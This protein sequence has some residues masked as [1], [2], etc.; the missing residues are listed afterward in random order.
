MADQFGLLLAAS[1]EEPAYTGQEQR[2]SEK[3][4]RNALAVN[5][6]EPNPRTLQPRCASLM[7]PFFHFANRR[8]NLIPPIFSPNVILYLSSLELDV[9]QL[10]PGTP[11]FL[12]SSSAYRD[13][14]F[15]SQQDQPTHL[16]HPAS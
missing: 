5:R 15:T 8:E 1:V 4:I 12:M 11:H 6:R 14:E 3:K 2:S 16:R 9:T 13:R 10:S 7:T